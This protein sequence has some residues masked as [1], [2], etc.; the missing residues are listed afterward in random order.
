MGFKVVQSEYKNV[1]DWKEW[2]V[3]TILV[4]QA[5]ME[6]VVSVFGIYL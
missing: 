1:R 3:L 5:V 4:F 6:I 2:V